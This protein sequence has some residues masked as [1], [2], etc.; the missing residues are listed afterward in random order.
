[1][2][3]KPNATGDLSYLKTKGILLSNT[4]DAERDDFIVF[5]PL[6]SLA[7]VSNQEIIKSNTIY[8]FLYFPDTIISEYYVDLS[9]LNSLP[10]E[11]ITTRIEQG[12]INKVGSLNRL[13]YYLFLCK[14]K[15]QLMHPE[16]SGVQIERA[17]V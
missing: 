1:M 12:K 9:W 7:A 15:V 17:V 4:C 11:I 2:F 5:A 8:Q 13:G 3:Y 16:D 14:I 10:R 6:L